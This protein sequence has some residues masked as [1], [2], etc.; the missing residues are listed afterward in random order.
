MNL[1]NS[2]VETAL[3]LPLGFD[4]AYGEVIQY[5][6]NDFTRKF[7]SFDVVRQDF[8]LEEGQKIGIAVW[9]KGRIYEDEKPDPY[10]IDG[11]VIQE[12]QKPK[13]SEEDETKYYGPPNKP[14]ILTG[15][16]TAIYEGGKV[17]RH[18]I[19]TYPGCSG[20]VIFLRDKN[21]RES[22]LD[23]DHGCVIGVHAVGRSEEKFNLGMAIYK[24]FFKMS[25]PQDYSILA[26]E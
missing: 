2:G 11:E 16:I 19:N 13:L 1:P 21:Q 9:R 8:K 3:A 24:D 10:E 4:V 7:V 18:N 17:F 26:E 20:A 14:V 12:S 25:R 15:E 23:E 6:E 22:V 5:P